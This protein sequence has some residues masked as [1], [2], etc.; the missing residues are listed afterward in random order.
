MLGDSASCP[1]NERL[2]EAIAELQVVAAVD[3]AVAVEIEEGFV[4]RR[5]V[6]G[7]AEDEVVA[8]VDDGDEIDVRGA[9]R[10]RRELMEQKKQRPHGRGRC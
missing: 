4:G 3:D 10:R 6:E 2:V 1:P 7:A 8:G 5:I 9:V